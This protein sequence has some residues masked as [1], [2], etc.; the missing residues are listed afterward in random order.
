MAKTLFEKS[1]AGS[2]SFTL[3]AKDELFTYDLPNP[4]QSDLALPQLNEVEVVRHYTNLAKMA[5]GVDEG[6]YPLGSCTMKYNPK[7]S[8]ETASL[9]GFRAVHPLQPINSTQGCIAVIKE[10]K[11]A[12]KALTGMADFSLAPAAGAHGELTGL[13]IVRKYHQKRKEDQRNIV[14]IPD[15]AHGTNPASANMCGYQVVTIPSNEQGLVD[16]TKLKEAVNDQVACLM[17]TNPNTLG[18]FE[19]NIKEIANIVHGCGGLLY[20]DGANLNAIMGICRP[21]DMGFDIVHLN[22]HKTF[23]TPHG[24]GGPGSGPLGVKEELQDYLPNSGSPLSIGQIIAFHGNFLVL[25]KALTYIKLL[26]KEGLITASKSA[27]LNANYLRFK[28]QEHFH[29]PYNQQGCMH[30]FVISVADHLK[31]KGISALDIAKAL[32]DKGIHPPT[33]YF[34]LIV[35]EALMIEPT[36]SE[37]RFTLDCF[38]EQMLEI[39]AD[40]DFANHPTTTTVSRIDEVKAAREPRLSYSD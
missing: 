1:V 32:I 2:N 27:V 34:P 13:L 38:V 11:T 12:L 8:E 25:V 24:G 23:G 30:E 36:E 4:R 33:I 10:L 40:P 21:F 17:L 28:L 18:L 39:L 37:S 22:L 9:A 29:I 14:L 15:S 20:Y 3:A 19:S 26:G 5:Y 7:L 35:K 16:L 31:E 6:F